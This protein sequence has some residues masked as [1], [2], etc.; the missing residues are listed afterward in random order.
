[1]N[2]IRTVDGDALCSCRGSTLSEGTVTYR[3]ICVC[4]DTHTHNLAGSQDG[5]PLLKEL[6]CKHSCL[7][8]LEALGFIGSIL[9]YCQF[10]VIFYHF[11]V[12]RACVCVPHDYGG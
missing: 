11:A 7:K 9:F 10:Y 4:P 8:I 5:S 2:I 3:K 12:E 6:L 1:M